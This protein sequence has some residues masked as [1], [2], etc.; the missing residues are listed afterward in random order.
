MGQ[1]QKPH[2]S[3]SLRG[4]SRSWEHSPQGP[5]RGVWGCIRGPALHS[6][7]DAV[8]GPQ[9][10]TGCSCTQISREALCWAWGGRSHAGDGRI[11]V[12]PRASRTHACSSESVWVALDSQGGPRR[13][14]WRQGWTRDD[15]QPQYIAHS[16]FLPPPWRS[17]QAG[18]GT[19]AN[20]GKS[21]VSRACLQNILGIN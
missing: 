6:G 14:S 12:N 1:P 16:S 19:P 7:V 5:R 15:Q 21:S 9:P 3:P 4:S 11:R 8:P 10:T 17:R 2:N 13:A 20:A 18:H